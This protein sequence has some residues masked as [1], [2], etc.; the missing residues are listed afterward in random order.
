MCRVVARTPTTAA[1][2]ANAPRP[3][4]ARATL[5]AGT[6]SAH[7]VLASAGR[8]G[9]IG[10]ETAVADSP[11]YAPDTGGKIIRQTVC[12]AATALPVPRDIT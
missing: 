3:T 4:C 9:Q 1:W 2:P 10:C 12:L 11:H 8:E 6:H 7:S 5:P